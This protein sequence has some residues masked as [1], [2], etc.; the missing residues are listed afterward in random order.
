[1]VSSFRQRRAVHVREVIAHVAG[2]AGRCRILDIG[3]NEPYWANVG[4]DF[5]AEHKAEIT[6]FNVTEGK[7]TSPR[8]TAM[9]GDGCALPFADNAFDMAHSNSVVE[10]VGDWPRMEAF[11]RELRRVAPSYYVQTPY[12]W[13]PYE[14]HFRTPFFHWLPE[15]TRVSMMLRRRHGFHGRQEDV[16]AATRS[17]QSARLV[18]EQQFRHLFPDGEIVREKVFGLTKSLMA[19]RKG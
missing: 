4:E 6:L 10:H 1:M 3:G 19:L 18:D 7:V 16:S 13:F 5:L 9:A 8:F 11:A 2:A 17:V 14:P 12:F 15:S